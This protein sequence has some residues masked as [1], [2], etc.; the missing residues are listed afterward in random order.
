[1]YSTGK[2]YRIFKNDS[3]TYY[4]FLAHKLEKP[5]KQIKLNNQFYS[6]IILKLI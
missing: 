2:W 1:M 4:I 3:S 5:Y 6:M